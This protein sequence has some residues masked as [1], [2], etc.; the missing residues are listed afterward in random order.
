MA[1]LLGV[2]VFSLV[3]VYF[4]PALARFDFRGPVQALAATV[5]NSD[6]VI[7]NKGN[8]AFF[9]YYGDTEPA[10]VALLPRSPDLWRNEVDAAATEATREAAR[11]FLVKN[12]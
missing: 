4:D 7:V 1:A 6:V 11:A 10:P 12:A 9:Y 3:H 8:P 2:S 5:T